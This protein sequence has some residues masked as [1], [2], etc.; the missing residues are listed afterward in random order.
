MPK[1]RFEKAARITKV[2]VISAKNELSAAVEVELNAIRGEMAIHESMLHEVE[3]VQQENVDA[4][5]FRS[6]MKWVHRARR[7]H[8]ESAEFCRSA[9]CEVQIKKSILTDARKAEEMIKI[10]MEKKKFDPNKAG[11][12]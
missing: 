7:E 3:I 5:I 9:Y 6:Y 2:A 4:I 11:D 10:L 1:N 12:G 8:D